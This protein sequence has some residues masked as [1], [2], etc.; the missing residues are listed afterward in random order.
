MSNNIDHCE[1]LKCDAWISVQDVEWLLDN[2]EHMLPEISFMDGVKPF[3]VAKDGRL[4]LKRFSWGGMCSGS[5]WGHFIR[6]IAP[7]IQGH[8]EAILTWEDGS[9]CG[10]RI[11]DGRV[12]EPEVIR[13]LADD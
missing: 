13:T 6:E 7:K 9:V 11:K 2:S 12:T 5:G 8:L 3:Q 4:I 1:T 10:L